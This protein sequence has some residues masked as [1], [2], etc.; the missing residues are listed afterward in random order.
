MT[1]E[2]YHFGDE[3]HQTGDHNIGMIKSQGPIEQQAA[4]SEMIAMVQI[5]RDRVSPADRQI[6]DESVAVIGS[7]TSADKSA[8]R[9]ALANLAGIAAIV[10]QVGIPAAESIR[11]VIDV[12]GV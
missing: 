7:D 2:H 11:R 5:L 1:G 12:F 10:N 3:V 4:L 8:F 9:R 6:I